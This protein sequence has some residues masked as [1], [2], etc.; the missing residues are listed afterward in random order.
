[1]RAYQSQQNNKIP[2]ECGDFWYEYCI[3]LK[4]YLFLADRYFVAQFPIPKS[5]NTGTLQGIFQ[6]FALS[7]LAPHT[8][9]PLVFW[10]FSSPKSQISLPNNREFH[11]PEQGFYH[12][13]PFKGTSIDVTAYAC[14]F[15]CDVLFKINLSII[16]NAL[17]T[18]AIVSAFVMGG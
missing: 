6:F 13:Q 11:S 16:P 10:H 4:L 3:N 18:A 8:A 15:L 14:S 17:L 5:I 9:N 1:M 12:F 7:F 2:A